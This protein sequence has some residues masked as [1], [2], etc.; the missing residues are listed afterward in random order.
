MFKTG[1][2]GLD[3]VLTMKNQICKQNDIEL[4]CLINGK[5]FL[6][7]SES[8]TYSLFGNIL[9]NA[10]E[11]VL[12]LEDTQKRVISIV[13]YRNKNQSVIHEENY[14]DG[15]VTF[16]DGLPRT[17]KGNE[18]IHGFGT[19]S[20]SLISKKYKGEVSFYSRGDVFSLDIL[21]NDKKIQKLK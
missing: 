5:D 17:T 16:K 9:D 15:E 1:N 18:D 7:M 3:I 14:F 20:I 10:I 12:K 4:T 11:A 19:K 13:S 6:F 2:K 8:E 21:F